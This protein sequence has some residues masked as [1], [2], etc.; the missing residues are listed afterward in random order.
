M[1]KSSKKELLKVK[2]L[3]ASI[4]EQYG[5]YNYDTGDEVELPAFYFTG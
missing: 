4:A 2:N 3:N 1:Y 5:S